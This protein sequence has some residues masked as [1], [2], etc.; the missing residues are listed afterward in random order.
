VVLNAAITNYSAEVMST[1]GGENLFDVESPVRY[2]YQSA[3]TARLII[4][5]C[6]LGAVIIIATL[7]DQY[8]YKHRAAIDRAATAATA[9]VTVG[10]DDD[11]GRQ[12]GKAAQLLIALSR[13]MESEHQFNPITIGFVPTSIQLLSVL[14]T[15]LTFLMYNDL[16]RLGIFPSLGSS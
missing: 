10:L 4:L 7:V 13:E 9:R 14:L 6:G 3:G 8:G 1:L 16:A 2:A 5:S 12:L 11:A 15:V